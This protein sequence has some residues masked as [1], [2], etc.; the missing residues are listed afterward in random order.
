MGVV[1]RPSPRYF[2]IFKRVVDG[3]H[4]Q[5]F[6]KGGSWHYTAT[7]YV[8][9]TPPKKIWTSQNPLQM[10]YYENMDKSRPLEKGISCFINSYNLSYLAGPRLTLMMKSCSVEFRNDPSPKSEVVH[11]TKFCMRISYSAHVWLAQLGKHQ[12]SKTWSGLWV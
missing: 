2:N 6:G 8:K 5:I 9:R 7:K 1:D 3:T 12:I 11:E 4:F 10:V